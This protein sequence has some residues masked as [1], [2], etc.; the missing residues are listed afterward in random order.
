M[1]IYTCT[2]FDGLWPVGTAAIVRAKSQEEAA[3]KM[4]CALAEANL[5]QDNPVLPENMVKFKKSQDVDILLN[6]EY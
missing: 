1:A 2:G 6:G 4:N 5:P 3:H